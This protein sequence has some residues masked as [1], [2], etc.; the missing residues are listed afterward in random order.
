[1][2]DLRFPSDQLRVLWL[3]L[4]LGVGADK[5]HAAL[6]QAPATPTVTSPVP[7]APSAKMLA[8]NRTA[9]ATSY[10]RH[11]VLLENGTLIN[12][13]ATSEGMV[14][15]VSWRG[16]IL[17]DLSSLLGGYFQAFK[18]QAERLRL[19]GRRGSPINIETD[20]LVVRSNG[21]MRNFFGHAYAP[22]L[23]PPGVDIKDVLH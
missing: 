2:S 5:V 6:G 11:E 4:L 23:I 21:R 7:Q 13:Y 19:V 14:F 15:A 12:E 18:V 10:T 17:P 9:Q 1:M 22:D 8:L 20:G 16:P 3:V